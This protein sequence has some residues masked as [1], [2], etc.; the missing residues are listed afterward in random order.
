[1]SLPRILVVDDDPELCRVACWTLESMA[2]CAVAH[3]LAS[4]ASL[5]DREPFDLALIDVALRDESGLALLDEL[6]QRWPDT[7]ATMISGT[8]DLNVAQAALTRGALA[9]LVKPF[10][11][12]DLRIHVATVCA[13]YRRM[14]V[15]DRSSPRTRIVAELESM[16]A[17][18]GTVMCAVV[19]FQQ[20]ALVTGAGTAAGEGLGGQVEKAVLR[21][22]DLQLVGALGDA[23]FVLAG[24]CAPDAS[25]TD[26][27]ELVRAAIDAAARTSRAPAQLAPRFVVGVSVRGDDAEGLL[28]EAEAC[29]RSALEQHLPAVVFTSELGREAREELRLLSDLSRAVEQREI[30]LAY[31]P[32]YLATSRRI[33]GVEA[34][35]RWHHPTRGDVPPSVFVPIAERSGLIELLGRQV[36]RAACR[37]AATMGRSPSEGPR[38]SVNVSVAQL[39]DPGFVDAVV[40]ALTESRLPASRL[41]LEVT[42]SLLLDDSDQLES[43]FERLSAHR[44]RLS[45]DDF[46]TGFSTFESLSRF[47]WSELKVDSVLTAQFERRCG[48]EILRSIVEMASKLD[49]DVVAEG[50]ESTEQLEAL[51]ALGFGMM[52]G[53]LLRRPIPI[54]ELRQDLARTSGYAGLFAN[55]TCATEGELTNSTHP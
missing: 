23:S 5:L 1:M 51:R 20:L 40:A 12:N 6:Q 14:R 24:R 25:M 44:I 31:Q 18:D 26:A 47:P 52:Q 3:D 55:R 37:D 9:Y 53:F 2:T 38:V 16:F 39:R 4:A 28:N 13:T 42:E 50:V 7:A 34:L 41:C 54:D 21:L 49:L 33:I 17:S 43:H 11:V 22:A 45:L 10:R 8:D 29:A 35:A 15:A 36:L 30:S 48:R 19:E 46:G 27:A 32:Q